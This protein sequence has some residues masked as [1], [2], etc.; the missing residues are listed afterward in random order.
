[1]ANADLLTLSAQSSAG[2]SI[3]S[4]VLTLLSVLTLNCTEF[5]AAKFLPI[6]R[7]I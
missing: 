1:M 3:T 6:L 4:P 5:A 7:V 2:R